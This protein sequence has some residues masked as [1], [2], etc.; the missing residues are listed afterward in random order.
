MSDN[1]LDQLLKL[2]DYAAQRKRLF[3]SDSSLQWYVRA[4]RRALIDS[5]ALLWHCGQWHA[6][7]TRFDDYVLEAGKQAAARKQSEAL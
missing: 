7:I 3:P 5:G 1:N 2:V 4:H 6:H